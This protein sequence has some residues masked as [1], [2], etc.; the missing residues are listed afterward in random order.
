M[1]RAHEEQPDVPATPQG[2]EAA[3]AVALAAE[4][5]GDPQPLT[6]LRQEGAVRVLGWMLGRGRAECREA[7]QLAH[8]VGIDIILVADGRYAVSERTASDGAD[9]LSRLDARCEFFDSALA[10]RARCESMSGDS[11]REAARVAALDHATRRWRPF[12]G[13][14]HRGVPVPAPLPFQLD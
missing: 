5:F 8:I 4:Q 2:S 13:T 9:G 3:L 12:R 14:P 1:R 11:T 7:G 10:A 6:L